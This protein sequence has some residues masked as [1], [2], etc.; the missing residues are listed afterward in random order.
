M[1]RSQKL[2]SRWRNATLFV[3]EVLSDGKTI[4]VLSNKDDRFIGRQSA[5]TRS[6][7]IFWPKRLNS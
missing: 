6:I 2:I 4:M 7:G 5:P 3:S 1:E